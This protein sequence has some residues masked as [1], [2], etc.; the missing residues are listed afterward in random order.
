MFKNILSLLFSPIIK[1][2]KTILG[3]FSWKPPFWISKFASS[4]GAGITKLS[5]QL[6]SS[7]ERNPKLFFTKL[8]VFIVL[9]S[10]GSYSI[11]WY[12]N[13]PKPHTINFSAAAPQPTS[14][15]NGSKPNPLLINFN[16]SVA[17]LENVGK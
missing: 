13:R 4:I 2:L 10:L 3:D 1:L 7:R 14:L 11:N 15:E 16:G 9:L 17:P 12:I 6:R 5:A 8:T